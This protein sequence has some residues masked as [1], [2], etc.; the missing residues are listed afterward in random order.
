MSNPLTSMAADNHILA[1]KNLF[2]SIRTAQG[3]IKAV[4]GVSFEISPGETFGL[5]GESG[6]GKSTLALSILRLVEPAAGR[7]EFDGTELQSLSQAEM[8]RH[9]RE[10]QVIF[11]DPYSSLAPRMAIREIIEE[12]LKIFGVGNAA[13]RAQAVAEILVAVGLERLTQGRAFPHQLSGGERQ[14]VAIARALVLKPR[15]IICDEP[16]SS[17]DVSIQAQILSLLRDLQKRFKLSYLFISHDL[18]V[19]KHMCR[20]VAVMYLGKIMEVVDTSRLFIH[21]LHPYTKALL[22]ALPTLA[23]EPAA[24]PLVLHGELPSPLH[25]PRGCPFN[26]R[27]PFATSICFQDEPAMLQY[28]PGHFAACHHIESDGM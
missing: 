15:L 28:D 13:D 22:S 19:I 12:P 10:L 21:P 4:N 16:V 7:V 17:L 6:C 24:G 14:R 25:I 26:T 2:T 18:R 3:T 23:H 1:V 8:N 5:V 20:R 9:R 27:C 11:Q